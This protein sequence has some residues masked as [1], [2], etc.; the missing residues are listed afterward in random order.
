MEF[1]AL[2]EQKKDSIVKDWFDLLI[3]SYS[4][5]AA[6]F[7]KSK[8]DQ[9]ANPVGS[10]LSHGLEALFDGIVNGNDSEKMIEILDP[11]VRIRAIQDFKPSEAVFFVVYLKKIIRKTFKKEIS[12]GLIADE[13]VKFESR[14]DDLSLLAFDVYMGCRETLFS[15]K[16]NQEKS[17]VFRAFKRAGLVTEV[18]EVGPDPG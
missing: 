10:T 8:D 17:K 16:A 4:A 2:L 5:D 13:L 3:G 7:M 6:R 1:K 14:V 18:E 9:F 15:I 11:V 12:N